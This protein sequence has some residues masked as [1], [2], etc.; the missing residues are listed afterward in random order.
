MRKLNV[1]EIMAILPVTASRIEQ[2][3]RGLSE[4]QLHARRKPTEWSINDIL[5]H[6]R[7]CSD[8]LGECMVRIVHE[9]EPHWN[10][11]SPRLYM[12]RKTDYPSWQFAPAF[13]AFRKQR[14]E[15]LEVL[16][17]L[18]AAAWL[19]YAIVKASKSDI[20]PRSLRF[21]GEWLARHEDD[22][23]PHIERIAKA[24]AR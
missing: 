16:T 3:T 20:R 12:A 18:P 24:L 19:R 8:V 10:R 14:G 5:A 21:Y 4:E 2:L 1:D 6:L 23:M 7:A 15:L 11:V 9:D 13:E 22:H 17:P